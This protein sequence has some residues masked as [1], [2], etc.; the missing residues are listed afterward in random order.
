MPL[1]IFC[2]ATKRVLSP[3]MCSV[4]DMDSNEMVILS[5]VYSYGQTLAPIATR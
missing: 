1:V 2:D 3:K 4:I 5:S